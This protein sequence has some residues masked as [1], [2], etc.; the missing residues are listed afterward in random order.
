MRW[1]LFLV[2]VFSMIF[3]VFSMQIAFANSGSMKLLA[4]SERL[5]GSIY[6]S[7]AELHLEIKEGGSGRVFLDT[8]PVTKL[9]TQLSTRFARDIA[10][11]FLEIN[12]KNLDFFYTIRAGSSIIGG[13]SGSAAIA[14]LT[15]ALLDNQRLDPKITITGTINSGG[16][17]GPV[18]GLKEK[19]DAAKKDGLETVLVS[20]FSNI[21][22]YNL[23]ESNSSITISIKSSNESNNVSINQSDDK[24]IK[25]ENNTINESEPEIE[26]EGERLNLTKYGEEIG[27]HIIEVSNIREAMHYFIGKSYEIDSYF[28]VD[29]SYTKIM[30]EIADSMCKRSIEYKKSINLTTEE[31]EIRYNRSLSLIKNGETAIQEED[32][33]S[34]SSYCFGANVQLKTI[35]FNSIN[36]TSERENLIQEF[37]D[38]E[39][40]INNIEVVSMNE[41]QTTMIVKER[42][43][44]AVSRLYISNTSYSVA[45]SSERLQSAKYWAKFYTLPSSRLKVDHNGLKDACNK[46]QTEAEQYYQYLML[47]FPDMLNEI[48]SKIED[49]NN[50]QRRRDYESC[51]L[52][53]SQAKAEASI[54]INLIGLRESEIKNMVTEKIKVVETII[55]EEQKRGIFPILGYSYYE[56]ANSLFED[57]PISAML[58]AEY[59]LEM[60]NFNFYFKDYEPRFMI[61]IDTQIL[62]VFLLGIGF[63]IIFGFILLKFGKKE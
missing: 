49:S 63:G 56:Y 17:I 54:L 18:G 14:A 50:F 34:A 42:L 33:Y 32:Y 29:E 25:N 37:E 9:D 20:K 19:I 6:G 23:T 3:L 57:D 40:E 52:K 26:I 38:F 15:I 62:G 31:D 44:E 43:R 1:K 28:F 7:I 27:I 30:K 24:I 53:S 8:T 41:L 55:S 61:D 4:T 46:K 39:N 48:R 45:Y 58:Y 22:N 59:A 5:D 11:D 35:L 36:L 10:C 2:S 16:I 60:S 47:F 13:P 12:C 21:I 51:L